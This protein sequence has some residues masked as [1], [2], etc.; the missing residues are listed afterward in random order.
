MTRYLSLILSL[1][2]DL[3]FSLQA[4][5]KTLNDT[6]QTIDVEHRIQYKS[7]IDHSGVPASIHL[8][9]SA[10]GKHYIH[11]FGKNG[12]P[13]KN[14]EVSLQLKHAYVQYSDVEVSLKTNDEGTIELGKLVDVQWIKYTNSQGAYKQWLINNDKSSLLPPAVCV[15]ANTS[16]KIACT[17]PS[18]S[19]SL[20]SLYKTGVRE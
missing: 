14:Y 11:A 4:K 19:D 2:M 8:R 3:K 7:P 13:K 18:L 10:D 12:E 9:R 20:F 5:I 17:S 15:P 6:L 1:V 16:F